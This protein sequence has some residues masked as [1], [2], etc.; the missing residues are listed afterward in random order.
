MIRSFRGFGELMSGLPTA[1]CMPSLKL[2]FLTLLEL[3]AL[4]A[5]KFMGSRDLYHTP[6]SKTNQEPSRECSSG[7][8][9]QT[10]SP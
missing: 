4:N 10:W 2:V 7:H 1:A 3:L 5:Q 6:F 9:R 8:A